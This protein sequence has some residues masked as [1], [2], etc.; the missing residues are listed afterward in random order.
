LLALWALIPAARGVSLVANRTGRVAPSSSHLAGIPVREVHFSASDGVAL[1]GWLA[2]ASPDAPTVILVHGF[3]SNRLSMLPWARYLYAAGYNVL[4][5]DSRGCGESAGWDIGVGA[6]EPNDIIGATRYLRALPDLRAKRFAALGVSL[7][8]GEVILAAAR[9]PDLRAVIADSPW[10][11]EQPQL[12]RMGS[13]SLGLLAL[14]LL[15][16]EPALVDALVGARLED[17][18]PVAV[19]GSITPRALMIITS[20][21]DA[22]TTTAPADQQRIFAAASQPKSH[23]V[24]PSGGHAGAAYAHPIEYEARTL[25]FLAQYLGAPVVV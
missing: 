19:A 8:A 17:A 4:L 10:A 21:D 9:D 11:D 22:N 3:K 7:G 12:D 5:Y 25:A 20:A 24:A 6:T 2:I 18:R 13:L 1:A 23:W 15:P 14:P 16:Y